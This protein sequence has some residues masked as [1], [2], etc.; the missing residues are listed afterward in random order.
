MRFTEIA[1][2]EDQL[3]L[4]RMVS[5]S[6]WKVFGQP[7]PTAQPNNTQHAQPNPINALTPKATPRPTVEPL[8][9]G[10]HRIASIR[11]PAEKPVKPSKLPKTKKAPMAPAPKPLPKPKRLAPTPLQIKNQQQKAQQ[12]HAAYLHKELV[13]KPLQ[14]HPGAPKPIP[15]NIISPIDVPRNAKEREQLRGQARGEL[16]WK[17]M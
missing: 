1:N 15:G 13:K 10:M 16:P 3:A 6:M 12:D 4:W 5:D 14:P 2:P 11:K 7:S 9:K 8:A 17:L